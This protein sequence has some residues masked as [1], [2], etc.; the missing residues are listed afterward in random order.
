MLAPVL[1]PL[2]RPAQSARQE[3]NQ[4]VFRIDMAFDAEAA[5]DIERD[6]AHARFRQAQTAAASRR[7]QCTTWVDD[8]M[9]IAVGARDHGAHHAAA[10]DR[11]RRRS[12]DDRNAGAAGAARR[13]SAASASPLRDG[14]AADEVGLERRG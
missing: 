8:Q 2:H 9:V 11:H 5:A 13:A 10:F 4:E 6:A 3:G 14:E 1:D 7:T 12:G